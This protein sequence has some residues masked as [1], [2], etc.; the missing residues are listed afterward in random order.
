MCLGTLRVLYPLNLLFLKVIWIFFCDFA[1]WDTKE[2][3]VYLEYPQEKFFI[4]V[5]L[6]GVQLD[7][8][9]YLLF[10]SVFPGWHLFVGEIGKN[11]QKVRMETSLF[12]ELYSR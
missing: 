6:T 3:F 10:I 2:R 11:F 12:P 1:S 8:V 9:S 5:L 4:L 7:P